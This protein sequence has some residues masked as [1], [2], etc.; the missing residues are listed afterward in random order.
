MR[1]IHWLKAKVPKR[2]DLLANKWTR[3]FAHKLSDPNI[4]HFNRRGVAR[5]V[6]LGMFCGILVP[7]GQS[8]VAAMF[9]VSARANLAVA[10]LCTFITNPFTTPFVYAS[11][12]KIGEFMLH[13]VSRHTG[14]LEHL[15]SD[16]AA[17][18]YDL[19]VYVPAGLLVISTIASIIGYIVIH[20]V[21]R[22]W[23]T[24]RWQA[25]RADR[26]KRGVPT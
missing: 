13:N 18:A 8:L 11:A 7:I 22:M 2:E 5:G 6:V 10:A 12:Y 23:V 26:V 17:R 24:Q 15:P 21:W 16:W 19:I 20:V 14:D 9:A 25:R 3:R 4:W 1:L